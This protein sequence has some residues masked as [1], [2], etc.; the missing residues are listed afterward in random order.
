VY[1][2]RWEFVSVINKLNQSKLH[3]L[4]SSDASKFKKVVIQELE[5]LK[6]W[7]ASDAGTCACAHHSEEAAIETRDSKIRRL[8]CSTRTSVAKALKV[9]SAKLVAL[10][11]ASDIKETIS[12]E[13]FGVDKI[14]ESLSD[15]V[16]KN[17][18][19][20][21]RV[22][23]AVRY[24]LVWSPPASSKGVSDSIQACE[25][26]TTSVSCWIDSLLLA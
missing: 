21:E 18:P 17:L 6:D 11:N 19:K 1:I 2:V 14:D 23:S 20:S 22:A 10:R 15:L 4:E 13:G 9:T 8:V 26:I 24:E 25:Q 7:V 12:L 5:Q 16:Q 3:T